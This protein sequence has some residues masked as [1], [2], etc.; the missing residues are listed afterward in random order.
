MQALVYLFIALGSAALG[1]AAYFG[2]GFTPAEALLL[3]LIALSAGALVMERRLRLRAE[4]RL[5]RGI[6]DL[7]RLLATDAQ[8]GSVLGRRINALSELNPG[9][10][11][12]AV[13]A[14]ISVLGTVIRQVAEAV[15]EIEDKA[16]EAPASASA[17]R[18]G[19]DS[20]RSQ[21]LSPEPAEE[22]VE[23]IIP[24]EM[25]RQAIAENRLVF[26]IQ[27]I[28]RLPQR[29]PAGYDLVPR[30]LLEDD[31]LAEPG[32]FL[33][34]RGGDDVVQRVEGNA[35]SEAV[36]IARRARTGG[37]TIT[38]NVPLSG[39]TLRDS[40]AVEQL[41]AV[42]DA[43]RAIAT[44][45]VFL[46]GEA[47]FQNLSQTAR[48]ALQAIQRRGSGFSLGATTSLRLNF[49]DLSELGVRSVRVNAGRLINSPQSYTDFHLSDIA[50]YVGRFDITLLATGVSDERQIVELLDNEILLVQGNHI[51]PA[52]PVRP[53]L[54]LEPARTVAPMALA[55]GQR[56]HA[57]V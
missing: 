46:I 49:A 50:S 42:L 11:L 7:S 41:I 32:D 57:E 45:L 9:Q 36:A 15:A 13:E 1:A 16:G 5:E 48:Q 24:T 30:L 4:R 39:S 17:E 33:P 47:D 8:A 14:D 21:T 29:R 3:S 43:N 44:N 23:P 31:D 20:K 51:A 6:E 35:L 55:Q 52:G 2:L 37:Q 40:A 56:R 25:V 34:R 53:D 22:E 54:L 18:F 28:A 10:R 38:V 19:S 12:E 26:H 27:P